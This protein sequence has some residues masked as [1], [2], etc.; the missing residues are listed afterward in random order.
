MCCKNINYVA[1]SSKQHNWF[2]KQVVGTI[3]VVNVWAFDA[4]KMTINKIYL[5]IKKFR[6]VNNM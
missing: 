6:E 3:F 1:N 4:F 5:N 2:T